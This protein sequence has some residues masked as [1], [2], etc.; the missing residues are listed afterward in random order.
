MKFTLEQAVGQKL[1]WSFEGIRDLPREFLAAIGKQQV[2]GVT[3]F[4]ALN[5]ESPEQVLALTRLLQETAREA[6]APPLLIAADQEG[7][8]LMALG[9]G[10]TPLPGR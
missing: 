9:Q 8:Q 3:L 7:G 6:S 4:R 10:T 1:L 2:G 5:V